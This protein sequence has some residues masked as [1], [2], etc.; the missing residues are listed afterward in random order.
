[1]VRLFALLLVVVPA[2]FGRWLEQAINP[3]GVRGP[4]CLAGASADIQVGGDTGRVL[5]IDGA[6][7]VQVAA[8]NVSPGVTAVARVG[9]LPVRGR[10]QTG[11]SQSAECR[12]Q[13]SSC[14]ADGKHQDPTTSVLRPPALDGSPAAT[15][16]CPSVLACA[17]PV[18]QRILVPSGSEPSRQHTPM[19]VI[20]RP[21]FSLSASVWV[22][23]R[24][25]PVRLGPARPRWGQL[26]CIQHLGA[27]GR[28]R[29]GG[30]RE[31]RGCGPALGVHLGLV[32]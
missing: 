22:Q 26:R 9:R 10:T 21:S 25:H 4:A 17:A 3:G 29:S 8:L 27:A 1:V 5:V 16:P 13:K 32:V 28:T 19:G 12:Y 20:P 31:G 24:F 23:P 15:N 14:P 7:N 2:A 11:A 30:K 6:A 18:Q